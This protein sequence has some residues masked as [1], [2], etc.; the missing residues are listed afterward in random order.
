M[1][2]S[3]WKKKYVVCILALFCAALWGMGYPLIKVGYQHMEIASDDT[4]SK[5]LFAG[6]RFLFAGIFVTLINFKNRKKVHF[7]PKLTVGIISLAM[8]Q[9]VLLN[10][11]QYIG[12]SYANGNISSVISQGNIFLVTFL[13][14]LFFRH[15]RLTLKKVVGA[16]I[17]LIGIVVMNVKGFAGGISMKGEGFVIIASVMM[18]AS[19][20]LSKKLTAHNSTGI[21][22]GLHQIIGGLTLTLA[23]ICGGGSLTLSCATAVGTL[24][25]LI[26]SGATANLLFMTLI[27]YN[28]ISEV[29]V[30]KFATPLFGV[31]FSFIL[32][33]ESFLSINNLISLLLVCL[34]IVIVSKGDLKQ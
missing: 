32:L 9:T 20:I 17:G 2:K 11:F 14:P 19:F 12:L 13:S 15:D 24:A 4:Y 6:V 8:L 28:D 27:K 16:F 1:K 29:A 3:M 33:G 18:A 30:Y 10:T 7:T 21:I 26:F 22:T 5:L 34:G 23:G 31:I 25:F